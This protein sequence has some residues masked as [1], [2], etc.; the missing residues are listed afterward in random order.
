MNLI[1]IAYAQTAAETDSARGIV[2]WFISL[3]NSSLVPLIFALAFLL[4]LFGV[5]KYFFSLG[6]DAEESRQKGKQFIL[7]AVIAFAVMISVWGLVNIL[8][9]TVPGLEN[10]TR[11]PLPCFSG[12]DCDSE[13]N[14]GDGLPAIY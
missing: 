6:S 9:R 10:Q 7:W 12:N 8:I 14:R 5:F 2:D 1:H 11:P 4:F 3:I 13:P